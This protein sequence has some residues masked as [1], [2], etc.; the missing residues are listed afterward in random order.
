MEPPRTRLRKKLSLQAHVNR[1]QTETAW[2][3]KDPSKF[4][5][6]RGVRKRWR[7]RVL[8]F[9]ATSL[10]LGTT[11]ANREFGC[12]AVRVYGYAL[13][14]RILSC[15]GCIGC[16]LVSCGMVFW[17]IFRQITK[18]IFLNKI[19]AKLV[20]VRLNFKINW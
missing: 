17:G 12:R 4:D 1:L 18:S 16:P 6:M 3:S 10:C 2:S 15:T 14:L 5:P 7:R 19:T 20:V 8:H 9:V 13:C 11:L